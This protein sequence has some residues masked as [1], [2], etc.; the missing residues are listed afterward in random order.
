MT[1]RVLPDTVKGFSDFIQFSQSLTETFIAWYIFI[2][3]NENKKVMSTNNYQVWEG[4]MEAAGLEENGVSFISTIFSMVLGIVLFVVLIA[5][6]VLQSVFKIKAKTK[7]T[8]SP[9]LSSKLEVSI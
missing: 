9:V 8:I 5:K 7:K 1:I 6:T 2:I 3:S 4:E